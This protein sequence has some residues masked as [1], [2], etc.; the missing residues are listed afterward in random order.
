M[1]DQA[2]QKI[3]TEMDSNKDGYTQAV[4]GFLLQ[5]L[6]TNPAAAEKI[7]A[8]GKT[9]KGSL[10]EMRKAAEKQKVG[11]CAVLTDAEGFAVVLKYY[12]IEG[13][14]QA[15]TSAPPA[16]PAPDRKSIDFSVNLDDLLK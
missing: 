8:E 3:K 14:A 12:G 5:H 9:I 11:N 7:M 13:K 16:A 2:I 15:A 4:G 6:E 1:L 10:D